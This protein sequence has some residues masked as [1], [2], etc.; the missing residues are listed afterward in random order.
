M[1]HQHM[2]GMY[3]AWVQERGYL[4]P[5]AQKVAYPSNKGQCWQVVGDAAERF[6]EGAAK[7]KAAVEAPVHQAMAKTATE[8]EV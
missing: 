4:K 7:A 6:K 1:W 2:K 3:R 8:A 5:V